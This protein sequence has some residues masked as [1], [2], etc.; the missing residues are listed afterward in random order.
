MPLNLEE[1]ERGIRDYWAEINRRSLDVKNREHAFPN[2]AVR[3]AARNPPNF[4]RKDLEEIFTWKYTD[5]RR[6]ARADDGLK[7]AQDE[8]LFQLTNKIG[9]SNLPTL[10]Q[11]FNGAIYGVG[12]AG[13]SAI[14]TAARPD[15]Y[16]VIDI[17]ALIAIEH[18]Y[19]PP[20]MRRVPRDKKGA[21]QADYP[22]YVPYVQFCTERATELTAASHR[23]WTPRHVDMALWAIGKQLSDNLINSCR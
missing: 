4:T 23:E 9:M 21:P 2:L 5:G 6:K 20:W 15:L 1:F 22:S 8:R 17:F 12:I 13:V 3:F 19:N 11:W 14:L 7:K 18:H 16:A 10:I